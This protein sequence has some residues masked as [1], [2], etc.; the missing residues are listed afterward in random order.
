[1]KKHS[2]LNLAI[3]GIL[4]ALAI[5][6]IFEC[7]A[8][9]AKTV[10]DD[11][12][13]GRDQWYEYTPDL[14]WQRRPN[15]T[16]DV[17]GQPAAFDAQ[18]YRALDSAQVAE[19]AEPFILTLGDSVTFGYQV[20]SKE[21]FS[22]QLDARLPGAAVINLGVN[23]YSSFQIVRALEDYGQRL[24][25]ALIVFSGHYNDRRYVLEDAQ[26][27][28]EKRFSQLTR[29]YRLHQWSRRV[30]LLR[31]LGLL[32]RKAGLLPPSQD[33][34]HPDAGL[35]T[36]DHPI[37]LETAPVRVE[38]ERYREQL[39]R[40]ARWCRAQGVPLIFMTLADNNDMTGAIEAAAQ[41]IEAG[42][43]ATAIARLETMLEPEGPFTAMARRMLAGLYR[44]EGREAEATAIATITWPLH[45][46]HGGFALH[47]AE[48]YN[49][50]IREV[51]AAEDV[52]LVEAAPWLAA[53]PEYYIDECHFNPAG[54]ARVAAILAEKI[55]EMALEDLG[56]VYATAPASKAPP[57]APQSGP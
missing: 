18:G 10:R 17:F 27:D 56:Q 1:M 5:L 7:S 30:Y 21:T 46:I 49:Q 44:G 9:I 28:S 23:G 50:I 36:I 34:D 25:P 32:M 31:G 2:R 43:S 41:A 16:G 14:N 38:P 40:A 13:R 20:A 51:A 48:V 55:A 52:P 42:D 15:F 26:I 33:P 6:I 22:E 29:R 37:N 3:K 8:R 45:T 24:N 54:H 35:V 4:T 47:R 12:Q 19:A 57:E 39:T 53:H 11:L